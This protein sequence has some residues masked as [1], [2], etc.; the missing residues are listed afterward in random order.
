VIDAPPQTQRVLVIEDDPTVAEVVARYLSRE[1]Y[2]VA[3]STDGLAGLRTALESPPDLVVLDLM[4]PGLSG[5]EVLSQLRKSTPVPVIMLTALS[6][7]ADRVSGLEMGAD[8]YVAKPFS[9]RELTARV[10]AVLRRASGLIEASGEPA[11]FA[12]GDLELDASTREV[13][14]NGRS[15]DLTAREFNLLAH[16]MRNPMKLFR[17]EEL[18]EQVWGFSY[19][20]TSTVTVHVSRLR[21]KVEPDPGSPRYIKTV[22]G[23]GYRF[24]P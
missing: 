13:R 2:S 7:E 15:L 14:L 21:E 5:V 19:G 8:D 22:R 10:K 16:F 1:G 18:L 24:V 4:L 6:R 3:V 11:A 20:D 23:F 9:P 12:A 17:R